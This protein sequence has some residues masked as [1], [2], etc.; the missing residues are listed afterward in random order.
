MPHDHHHKFDPADLARL[1]DP[2]RREALPPDR[3]AAALPL[4]SG[5]R[6]ADVGCGA[7]FWLFALLEAAPSGVRFWAVDTEPRM[8]EHLG[9]RLA[10]HPRKADVTLLP[11]TEH[12]VPLPER[13]LDVIVLGMVYHELAD[14]KAYL[15]ELQRLLAPGGRLALIDWDA[16]PPGTER[17]MG[18]PVDERVPFA[19]AGRELADAGFGRFTQIEGFAPGTYG[20]VALRNAGRPAS[21]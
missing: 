12:G 19:V 18:P 5:Q 17:T 20:V 16:L 4:A 15:A 8:L 2:R 13:A 14:R 9:Q 21:P 3:L 11:S 1:D 10:D 6:V 7:G